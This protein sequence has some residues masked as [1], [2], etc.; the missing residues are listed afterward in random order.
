MC[1]KRVSPRY[2]LQL[3]AAE[4]DSLLRGAQRPTWQC[5]LNWVWPLI[6]SRRC[7]WWVLKRQALQ[8]VLISRGLKA[9][10]DLH[11]LCLSWNGLLSVAIKVHRVCVWV[12]RCQ[13]STVAE[14]RPATGRS[15]GSQI[16]V[17]RQAPRADVF[18]VNAPLYIIQLADMWDVSDG[19]QGQGCL[20]TNYQTARHKS[21]SIFPYS[22]GNTRQ[23]PFIFLDCCFWHGSVSV[24]TARPPL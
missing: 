8:F 12:S 24:N 19:I 14:P 21:R 15:T 23:A 13:P 7:F 3:A 22:C 20:G 2:N 9:R 4:P 18:D 1:P 16:N 5:F 17:A 11:N 10:L 6:G